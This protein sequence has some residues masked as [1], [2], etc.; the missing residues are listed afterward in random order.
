MCTNQAALATYCRCG[1]FI[2]I[3]LIRQFQNLIL[4]AGSKR[5]PAAGSAAGMP[6]RFLMIAAKVDRVMPD[7]RA[8][9][10][11]S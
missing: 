2:S 1:N 8:K 7:G 6:S 9:T 5:Y 4:G 3:Q 11:G 10:A